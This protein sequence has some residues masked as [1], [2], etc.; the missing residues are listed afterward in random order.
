M[1]KRNLLLLIGLALYAASFALP[2]ISSSSATNGAVRGYLCAWITLTVPW[3]HD[4][5]NV[6]HDKP[7]VYIA[8]LVSGLTNVVFLITTVMMLI[9]RCE[10]LAA[11][12]RVLLLLM[13]PCSW[14]ILYQL[15]FVPREG[16]YMWILG[17]LLTVFSNELTGYRRASA[18]A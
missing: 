16:H 5:M 4:G 7:F 17:M 11:I 13:L 3:G 18:T 12:F 14:F 6:F 1:V 9:K 10:K 2:A 8:I 15:K